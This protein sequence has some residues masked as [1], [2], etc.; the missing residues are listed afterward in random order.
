MESPAQAQIAQPPKGFWVWKQEIKPRRTG[1]DRARVPQAVQDRLLESFSLIR[2]DDKRLREAYERGDLLGAA[3]AL[4]MRLAEESLWHA[5]NAM[6]LLQIEEAG[7]VAVVDLRRLLRRPAEKSIAKQ[8]LAVGEF[9]L[10]NEESVEYARSRSAALVTRISA[11]T[12]STIRDLVTRSFREGRTGEKLARDIREVV[13]L[14]PRQ[15]TALEN[16]RRRLEVAGLAPAKITDLTEGYRRRLLLQRG[17]MIA[18]TEIINSSIQG[19]HAVW[20]QAVEQN[21][22]GP[23]TKRKWIVAADDRLCFVAGTSVMTPNGPVAIE[24]LRA[25]DLVLTHLGARRIIATLRQQTTRPVVIVSYG[26]ER[27]IV[28][29]EHPYLV[30]QSGG[31]KWVEAQL[32]E[33]GDLLCQVQDATNGKSGAEGF[34][35]L[36]QNAENPPTLLLEKAFLPSI[37]RF[38]TVPVSS[39]NLHHQPSGW[40]QEVNTIAPNLGFLNKAKAEC[41]QADANSFF[42]PC[43]LSASSIAGERTESSISVSRTSSKR[44]FTRRAP[45]DS[46]WSSTFF[47]AKLTD[48]LLAAKVLITTRAYFVFDSRVPALCRANGVPVG[49][50]S[51]DTEAL[52]AYRTDLFDQNGLM[53]FAPAGAGTKFPCCPRTWRSG[54]ALAAVRTLKQTLIDTRSH[55]VAFGR[56]I[57]S[58]V[59]GREWLAA[60]DAISLHESSIVSHKTTV[61]SI[62]VEEAETFIAGGI[63]VH[64]CALCEDMRGKTAILGQP[65]DN[66]IMGPTRHPSCR[67]GEVLVE[68]D[69]LDELEVVRPELE[70]VGPRLL[71]EPASPDFYAKELP[72]EASASSRF[73]Y[74]AF[75]ALPGYSAEGWRKAGTGSEY[76]WVFRGK[77]AAQIRVADHGSVLTD[78]YGVQ[79]YFSTPKRQVVA[80][81]HRWFERFGT[82]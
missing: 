15:A 39:V 22:M 25:G 10:V 40:Q 8:S 27:V 31:F 34:H 21:L 46:W 32:L 70:V 28:T 5:V 42:Q 45:Q 2:L 12:K 30:Q 4:E 51:T 72:E 67:C 14:L 79:V 41:F 59:V 60:S 80:R 35:I 69:R 57:L 62:Q 29:A 6:V 82:P 44:L 78:K 36:F 17:R 75:N 58:L 73:V 9:N 48:T 77:A 33:K 3:E 53:G 61:Y 23:K 37:P 16:F 55:M 63:L 65:Y 68:I 76:M 1:S 18:R 7:R 50:G 13:G 26:S 74:Q 24:I 56:A 19:Q 38:V 43:F 49:D 20:G 81:I 11:D 71:T 52:S 64:N 54:V 47:R 66:G